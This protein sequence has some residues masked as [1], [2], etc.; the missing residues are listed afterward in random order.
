M[1]SAFNEANEIRPSAVHVGDS[2]GDAGSG[3]GDEIM[4]KMRT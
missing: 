3:N 2:I 4:V 1:I